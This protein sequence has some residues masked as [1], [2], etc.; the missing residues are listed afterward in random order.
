MTSAG[1]TKAARLMTLV[2]QADKVGSR[3]ELVSFAMGK[4]MVTKRTAEDYVEDVIEYYK[5]HPELL[6]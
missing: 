2:K 3:D 5:Q 1:A 4:F 6:K